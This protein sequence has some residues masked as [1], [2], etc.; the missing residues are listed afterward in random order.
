M[1]MK[2]EDGQLYPRT[3]PGLLEARRE[4]PNRVYLTALRSNSSAQ[5]PV[6]G[7]L[8]PGTG[9]GDISVFRT[10]SLQHSVAAKLATGTFVSIDSQ[11]VVPVI[12]APP[13]Y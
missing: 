1:A 2:G 13:W 12:G 3:H 5:T 4:A 9:S 11:H 7:L 10:S 8:D 6:L